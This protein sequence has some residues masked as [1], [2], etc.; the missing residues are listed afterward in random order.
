MMLKESKNVG[1]SRLVTGPG[2]Q[3]SAAPRLYPPHHFF[4]IE[5][6]LFSACQPIQRD[7]IAFL[8]QINLRYALLLYLILG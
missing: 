6:K 4:V 8:Q 5:E 2:V 3:I 1:N 7:H